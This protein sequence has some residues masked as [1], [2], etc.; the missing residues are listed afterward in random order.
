[1]DVDGP[2]RRSLEDGLRQDLAEGDDHGH[3]GAELAKPGRPLGVAQARGLE[4]RH[5]RRERAHLH[6]RRL[7]SPAAVGRAVRLRDDG[8][9]VVAGEH[10]LERRQR[11]LGRAVE[12]DAKAR[13]RGGRRPRGDLPS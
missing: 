8:D 3:V 9:D 12:E 13:R 5:A 1:M 6:G 2:A 7:E 11:E 10:R 4:D